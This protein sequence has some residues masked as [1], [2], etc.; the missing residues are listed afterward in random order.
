MRCCRLG[1][2]I[3]NGIDE[4]L[5]VY[6]RKKMEEIDVWGWGLGKVEEKWKK[7]VDFGF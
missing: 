6:T 5:V 3:K 4:L 7:E 2:I 1:S